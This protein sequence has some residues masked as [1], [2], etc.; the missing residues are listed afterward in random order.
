MRNYILDLIQN[1]K[2]LPSLPEITVKLEE[3]LAD[4]D[5]KQTDIAK[6]NE[7]E[8]V[9]SGKIKTHSNSVY[10]RGITKNTTIPMAI[11]RL[12]LN[13]VRD[14]TYS[15]ILTKLFV[16]KTILKTEQFWIHS[17]AVA[18]FSRSLANRTALYKEENELAYLS[19][20]MH[21][22][23][24]IVFS[25]IIPDEY[26]QFLR[27]DIN[28]KEPLEDNERKKFGIDHAELG[29]L[30]IEKRWD[31][32]KD[33]VL[34]VR[35]HH[36][37]FKGSIRERHFSQIVHISNGLCN[38]QGITVGITSCQLPLKEDVLQELF[39]H[40]INTN[41]IVQEVKTSLEEAKALLYS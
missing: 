5:S 6:L 35:Q 8:P 15:L 18:S 10:Y 22:I 17:L 3:L 16:D 25:Y 11:R 29:A 21:D 39:S 1:N 37:P 41:D 30:F 23:G 9:L 19:G 14:L 7:T 24:L 12:G 28:D 31:I 36:F 33:I 26:L 40:I 2:D 20:L 34:A 4:P 32:H 27:T 38:D 13:L